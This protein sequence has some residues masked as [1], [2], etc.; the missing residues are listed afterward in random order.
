MYVVL[1]LVPCNDQQK[2]GLR[3]NALALGAWKGEQ[4]KEYQ[5]NRRAESSSIKS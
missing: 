1:V 5:G 3:R 4:I 2:H